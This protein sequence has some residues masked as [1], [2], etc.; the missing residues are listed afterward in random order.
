M[1]AAVLGRRAEQS[2]VS[3][4]GHASLHEAGEGGAERSV[5]DDQRDSGRFEHRGQLHRQHDAR[6]RDF[7]LS[8]QGTAFGV[9]HPFQEHFG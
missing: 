2:G 8:V 6:R 9:V 7:Q 1:V 3:S 5:G 4:P